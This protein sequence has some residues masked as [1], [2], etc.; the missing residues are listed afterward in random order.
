[1]PG[2]EDMIINKTDR[3]PALVKLTGKKIRNYVCVM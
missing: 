1:M 2:M 3:L